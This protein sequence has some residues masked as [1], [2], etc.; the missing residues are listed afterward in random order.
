ME[1]YAKF[2][3]ICLQRKKCFKIALNRKMSSRFKV[4]RNKTNLQTGS[5]DQE[6]QFTKDPCQ[7]KAFTEAWDVTIWLCLRDVGLLVL[8]KK[9]YFKGICG[10]ACRIAAVLPDKPSWSTSWSTT[11]WA[12][13][14]APSTTT[15][16]WPSAPES[17]TAA[18]SKPREPAHPADSES[19]RQ[20][21]YS[22]LY[23]SESVCLCGCRKEEWSHFFS[24]SFQVAVQMNLVWLKTTN[25]N[26]GEQISKEQSSLKGQ[27]FSQERRK[28]SRNRRRRSPRRQRNQ[29]QQRNRRRPSPRKKQRNL[30]KQNHQR[31]Q[32]QRRS[33]KPPNRRRQSLPRRSQQR[34]RPKSELSLWKRRSHVKWTTFTDWKVL[35]VL[36]ALHPKLLNTN[37]LFIRG[38]HMKWS[39]LSTQE[40]E[41]YIRVLWTNSRWWRNK[42]PECSHSYS[43]TVTVPN[44]PSKAAL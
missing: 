38:S 4:Q 25:T 39:F 24:L 8:S 16:S 26:R 41:L 13:T 33:Q 27:L 2:F 17:R 32:K 21:P 18:S 9:H 43:R 20:S 19:V 5:I 40:M 1:N 23:F 44:V 22:W 7:I 11:T 14:S 10:F 42:T 15:W 30:R 37:R 3:Y 29:K 28:L 31:N 12:R 36:G 35:G 6:S 34:R